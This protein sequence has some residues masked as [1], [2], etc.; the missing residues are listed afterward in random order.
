[1]MYAVIR[2]VYIAVILVYYLSNSEKDQRWA[3]LRLLSLTSQQKRRETNQLLLSAICARYFNGEFCGLTCL[4]VVC[5]H[6]QLL[7][8]KGLGIGLFKGHLNT[9]YRIHLQ[10]TL[11]SCC[12]LLFWTESLFWYFLLASAFQGRLPQLFYFAYQ[13]IHTV[14]HNPHKILKPVTS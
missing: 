14:K 12:I 9:W 4:S 13:Q 11:L 8:T 10:V 5:H 6:M 7:L 3:K 1:M 2:V